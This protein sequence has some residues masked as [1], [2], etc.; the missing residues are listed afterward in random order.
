MQSLRSCAFWALLTAPLALFAA[1]GTTT[2]GTLAVG[3]GGALVDGNRAAYQQLLQQKKDGYGG[4]EHFFLTRETDDRVFTLNLRALP[5]NEDYLLSLRYEKTDAF[6][7]DAGYSTFR[8][9]YDDSGGYFVPSGTSFAVPGGESTYVDRSKLWFEVGAF[10]ANKTYLKARYEHATRDGTK[11]STI[12]GDTGLVSRPGGPNY[13]TK[14]LFPALNV[15]DETRDVV[16]LEAGNKESEQQEWAVGGRYEKNKLDNRRYTVRSSGQAAERTVAQKDST[17]S[18]M[19]AA[20]GYYERKVNE[21]L[22]VSAGALIDRL[23]TNISGSRIYGQSANPEFDPLSLHRQQRDEGFYDLTGDA[24]MRQTVLN[25]NA[26]YQPAEHLSIRP[27]LRYENQ[28]QESAAE[29]FETNVGAGPSFV[30]AIEEL[31]SAAQKKFNEVTGNLEVRYTGKPNWTYTFNAE[32]L[33]GEGDLDEEETDLEA[34]AVTLQRV[35][36]FKRQAQKYSF[37]ANWYVRPGLTIAGQYYYQLKL[38]D[39]GAS[40]DP[41]TTAADRYP[42]YIIDQDFETHDANLRIAWRPK[43]MLSFVTR[44]DLQR[45]RVS[46]VMAG[47]AK[48]TSGELNTRIFSQSVSWSPVPRLYLTGTVNVTSDKVETPAVSYVLNGDNNYVNGTFGAG[49]AVDKV[50]D[51][52]VDYALY[53]ANNFI[54]NSALSLPYGADQRYHAAYVTYVRRHTPSI[55]YTVKYGYV[56][57]R[58]GLAM[59]MNDFDAHVIYGRVQ[60]AF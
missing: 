52:Y 1:D 16:T 11:N 47:L 2:G 4:I 13:G 45:T 54:D 25:L 48:V 3:G 49:Y 56:T 28:H 44:Y 40:I 29:F 51:L 18:D 60:Y 31:E 10:T 39:Y 46:S 32:W 8:T 41:A 55:T 7:I 20:H 36:D 5:G 12:W 6:Y 35:S 57:N 19:F 17:T 27:S 38:N 21:Q 22:R 24:W 15:L 14:G 30:T 26:V 58:D 9:F 42:A 33:N 53:H 50:S 59:G 34:H 37:S 43:S 23:D